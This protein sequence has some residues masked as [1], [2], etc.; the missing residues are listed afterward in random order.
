[1]VMCPFTAC[2]CSFSVFLVVVLYFY[3]SCRSFCVCF[4]LSYVSL[5]SLNS[6]DFKQ[7][8]LTLTSYRHPVLSDSWVRVWVW[9]L[10]PYNPS[11]DLHMRLLTIMKRVFY[12]SWYMIKR[13]AGFTGDRLMDCLPC[14]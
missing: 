1:M 3:V 2:L 12:K 7:G 14:T 10:L 9:C 8:I 5:W 11:M 13:P 4:W 6:V